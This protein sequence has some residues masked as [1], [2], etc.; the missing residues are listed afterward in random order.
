[1]LQPADVGLGDEAPRGLAFEAED[2]GASRGEGRA[3][4][5]RF[6]SGRR[7]TWSVRGCPKVLGPGDR[8]GH[9]REHSSTGRA[10]RRHRSRSCG[11]DRAGGQRQ[12]CSVLRAPPS[13]SRRRRR[14]ALAGEDVWSTWTGRCPCRH[15]TACPSCSANRRLPRRPFRLPHRHRPSRPH[16]HHPCRRH[17]HHHLCHHRHLCP[18]SS[19]CSWS[20]L[21]AAMRPFAAKHTDRAGGSTSHLGE[22][23]DT[24]PWPRR[25]V[26][27]SRSESACSSPRPGTRLPAPG[28]VHRRLPRRL[29]R[30]ALSSAA[31]PGTDKALPSSTKQGC[32]GRCKS[33][34]PP[35]GRPTPCLLPSLTNERSSHKVRPGLH[36]EQPQVQPSRQ[37]VLTVL[38][39]SDDLTSSEVA[40]ALGWPRPR[41]A[42]ALLRIHRAGLAHR[43]ARR[44]RLT[45][46]GAARLAWAR[47]GQTG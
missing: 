5:A 37:A 38:D 44:Y 32:R 33:A 23:G 18:W 25:S 7:G 14:L 20:V 22:R 27:P 42:M 28:R 39:L 19:P 9:E 41:A 4:H 2:I 13:R 46:K 8:E 3:A 24:A 36:R 11:G 1:M 34:Y 31:P 16:L 29:P 6:G 26:Q 12:C 35:S 30:A 21:S 45:D 17:R 10:R 47:S 15:P 43:C 40:D